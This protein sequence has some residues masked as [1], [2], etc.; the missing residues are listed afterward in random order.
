MTAASDPQVQNPAPEEDPGQGTPAMTE[1][2]YDLIYRSMGNALIAWQLVEG[3]HFRLFRKLLGA[4]EELSPLVYFS[5]ESFDTRRKMLHRVAQCFLADPKF[6]ALRGQWDNLN[7]ELKD[8][9]DNRNKIAHYDIGSD[10]LN[11]TESAEGGVE[12][13]FGPPRLRP[14]G[15]NRVSQL[16]GRTP[17][18]EAHNLSHA[19]LNSYRDEFRSL[20]KLLTEFYVA[21]DS[22]KYDRT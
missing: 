1:N 14:L 4:P 18:Q 16:D 7:K 20:A 10:V 3:A 12:I 2:A 13:E 11:I 8:A 9:N 6:K 17:D 22:V 21:I 5:I 15:Y 19:E